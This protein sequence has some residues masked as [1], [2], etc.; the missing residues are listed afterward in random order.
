[1]VSSRA[2]RGAIR[3]VWRTM[4]C[5]S[6]RISVAQALEPVSVSLRALLHR[7]AG[8]DQGGDAGEEF[9]QAL[10]VR[11]MWCAAWMRGTGPYARDLA[12][13]HGDPEAEGVFGVEDQLFEVEA[14][15]W[16][17]Q[18]FGERGFVLRDVDELQRAMT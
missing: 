15:G 2:T 12:A 6:E 16:V 13:A 14:Q 9:R 7:S 5:E 1:M 4:G 11:E 10:G 18:E 3:G 17:D 8:F